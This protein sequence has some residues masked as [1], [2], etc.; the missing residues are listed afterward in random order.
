MIYLF[1]VKFLKNLPIKIVRLGEVIPLAYTAKLEAE[2]LSGFGVVHMGGGK[3]PRGKYIY[4]PKQ[5]LKCA[6]LRE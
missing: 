3:S 5:G 1:C 4:P 2:R 6:I